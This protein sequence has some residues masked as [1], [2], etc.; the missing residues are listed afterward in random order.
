M[1]LAPAFTVSQSGISPGTITITDTSTGSDSNIFAR[2]VYFQT[3]TGSYIVTSGNTLQ[4][5]P[6]PLSNVSQGFPVLTQDMALSILVQ[7]VDI[8]G[9]VLYR[10]SQLFAFPQYNKNFFY[11]LIKLNAITPGDIQ[12]T[13]YF[14]NVAQYWMLITGAINAIVIGADIAASQNL[15]NRATN[16]MRNEAYYF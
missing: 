9:N 1:P 14:Q 8:N 3:A 11:A 5:E 2:R 6:W 13:T 12:D 16:M 7:W 15:F 10:L 4:Y